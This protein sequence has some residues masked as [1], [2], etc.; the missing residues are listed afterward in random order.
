MGGG[1][2]GSSGRGREAYICG[3]GCVGR[4]WGGGGSCGGGGA[5]MVDAGWNVLL[6]FEDDSGELE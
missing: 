4:I 1:P 2:V 6:L 3:G 5:A